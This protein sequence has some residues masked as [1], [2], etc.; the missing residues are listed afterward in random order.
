MK[1]NEVRSIEA[2]IAVY[3]RLLQRLN[4]LGPESDSRE[5]VES[6]GEVK[7]YILEAISRYQIKLDRGLRFRADKRAIKAA[8]L[9][10]KKH[11]LLPPV[12]R[13]HN[14]GSTGVDNG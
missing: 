11:N 10:Q 12:N 5:H 4:D 7:D 8:S 1:A 9:R 13:L 3:K 2:N 6:F 14:G